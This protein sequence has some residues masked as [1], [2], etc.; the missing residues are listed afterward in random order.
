M[1]F[2]HVPFL[3]SMCCTCS[4]RH[5]I[6]FPFPVL[7][8][9]LRLRAD[10]R[11]RAVQARLCHKCCGHV[12]GLGPYLLSMMS[13][14]SALVAVSGFSSFISALRLLI[15]APF[16]IRRWKPFTQLLFCHWT[17]TIAQLGPC[18]LL[19][20]I[21][22]PIHGPVNSSRVYLGTSLVYTRLPLVIPTR[23]VVTPALRASC[24]SFHL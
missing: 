14:P 9:T 5:G 12:I 24:S 17:I 3:W 2:Y 15:S 8:L 16:A 11:C 6:L 23:P 21:Y 1:T 19:Y 22:S 20:S 7:T 18:A 10:G 4:A 13:S